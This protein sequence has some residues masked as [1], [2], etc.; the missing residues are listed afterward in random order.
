MFGSIRTVQPQIVSL[1]RSVL[2]CG[3]ANDAMAMLPERSVQTVVTS[4]PYWSLRDYEVDRQIGR[5]D[6]LN[7]TTWQALWRHSTNSTAF[8]RTMAPCG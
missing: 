6:P 4:P 5:D 3:C 8:S 1:E 7:A 2:L